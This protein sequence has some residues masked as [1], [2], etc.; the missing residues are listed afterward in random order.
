MLGAGLSAT[1]ALRSRKK[2]S[3]RRSQAVIAGTRVAVIL[4]VQERDVIGWASSIILVLTLGEQVHEQWK[5]GNSRGV[6]PWLFVG[7]LAASL[8][9]TMYSVL[10]RNWVF[11]ITNLLLVFNALLG[12]AIVLRHRRR[13]RRADGDSQADHEWQARIGHRRSTA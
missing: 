9:F 8:G 11:V 12:Q 2:G 3:A 4:L 1:L 10:L 6:S 5:S 7:Q 13:Q